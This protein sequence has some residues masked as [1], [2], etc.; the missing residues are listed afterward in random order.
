MA[1]VS[2]KLINEDWY[3][4]TG[5]IKDLRSSLRG[6]LMSGV[7]ASIFY[8]KSIKNFNYS[9][10]L[11]NENEERISSLTLLEKDIHNRYYDILKDLKDSFNEKGE[12]IVDFDIDKFKDD[13]NNENKVII[14]F[15]YNV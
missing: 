5:Q 4:S 9:V 12:N 6:N 3:I 10:E 15:I 13:K 7:I 11:I 2:D 14:H 8:E 1:K